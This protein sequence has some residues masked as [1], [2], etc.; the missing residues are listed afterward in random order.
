MSPCSLLM[1]GTRAGTAGGP[2]AALLEPGKRPART[3]C[4]RCLCSRVVAGSLVL[5][6]GGASPPSSASPAPVTVHGGDG[7]CFPRAQVQ[8]V[9]VS[10]KCCG[11]APSHGPAVPSWTWCSPSVCEHF[12]GWRPRCICRS[13]GAAALWG[14]HGPSRPPAG[15]GRGRR[16]GA[17][18][19]VPADPREAPPVTGCRARF[20]RRA[21]D[22][23]PPPAGPHVRSRSHPSADAGSPAGL[24]SV[25]RERATGSR[26]LGSGDSGLLCRASGCRGCA[27]KL[28]PPQVTGGDPE[29]RPCGR[30]FLRAWAQPCV[31]RRLVPSRL[32]PWTV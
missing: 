1:T 9:C 5:W 19:Q 21:R 18:A 12:G 30:G 2:P 3:R 31:S 6:R 4:G 28:T 13:G 25:G 15:R 7:G 10:A 27:S 32:Q 14:S 16:G 11:R 23:D 29:S 22:P 17:C 24:A 26:L 20:E 8:P